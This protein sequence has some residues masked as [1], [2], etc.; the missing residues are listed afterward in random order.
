MKKMAVNSLR[1]GVFL[2][3]LFSAAV[4]CAAETPSAVPV[5]VAQMPE[6]VYH[7]PL[8][9]QGKYVRHNFVIRNTG[10]AVLKVL[11]VKTS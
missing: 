6:T 8:T 10:S 5:P 9:V 1:T 3:A 2:M 4:L 11:N 7:F